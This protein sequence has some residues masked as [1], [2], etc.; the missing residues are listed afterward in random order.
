M[1]DR[2]N[3]G[4]SP[5]TAFRRELV[6]VMPGYK[7]TVHKTKNT[8]RISATG[9]QSSD[10]NRLSTLEVTRIEGDAS[11]LSYEVKSA[12]HG[13]KSAWAHTNRDTTL[14]RA[15]RGLQ[16]HYVAK[17]NTYRQ[18][19]QRLQYGRDQEGGAA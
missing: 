12:P 16:D 15:L 17:A 10:F 3:D 8:L 4:G 19:A 6:Q 14:R 1:T 2:I 9:I 11:G 18:L 7:W 5:F 13:T